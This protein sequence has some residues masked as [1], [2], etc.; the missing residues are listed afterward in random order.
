MITNR[1]QGLVSTIIPVHN[2]P[3]E[4]VRAV[5]S[6]LAQTYQQIEIIIV[7]D[8]STDSTFAV[9]QQLASG[10]P[11]IIYAYSQTNSGP[12]VAREKG[13]IHAN[14]EFIQYLD[15]DDIL[16]PNKFQLQVAELQAN[17]DCDVSYGMVRYRYADGSVTTEP[18]KHTGVCVPTV[19]PLMLQYRWWDT[20]VP[21]YRAEICDRAGAWTG[22]RIEEDWEYDCRIAALDVKLSYCPEYVCE[23]SMHDGVRLSRGAALDPSRLRDRAEAHELI[24]SHAIKAGITKE[25]SEMQHFSKELFLLSRQC[26]AAGLTTESK[27]LFNLSR[28]A[29]MLIAKDNIKYKCYKMIASLIGWEYTGKLACWSD[30]WR[31]AE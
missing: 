23:I 14:G 19:F 5:E 31:N 9:A 26:G 28:Q 15:S 1:I 12:G 21:L 3:E 4:L 17:P 25:Q 13:R 29:S 6:V 27:K 7:D 16:L 24:L 30:R 22:L 2:R 8:G 20:P 11:N 10:Y 18:Q